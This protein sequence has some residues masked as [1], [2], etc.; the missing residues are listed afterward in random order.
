MSRPRIAVGGFMHETNTFAP[1][2]ADFAAFDGGG[3]RP[4][5]RGE[6]VI[7]L[8]RGTNNGIAG[9]VESPEAQAWEIVPTLW[10]HASP[11][12]HVTQDAFDRIA[13]E[14]VQAIKDAGPLD[15]I[16]LNLHGAMVAEHADDGEGELLRRVRAAMGDAIPIVVSL[17]LHANVTEEMVAYSDALIGYRTYPHVDMADTGARC[18]TYM[19]RIVGTPQRDAKAFRRI[20]FLIPIVWQ[21]TYIEPCKSLYA[22]HVTMEA[23]GLPTISFSTGFPA[24]DIPGCAPTVVAYAADAATAERAADE[25]ATMVND[26]ESA[27]AGQ[28]WT[29]DE[30]VMEAMRLAQTASKPVVIAD[31]QDNPGAGGDSDTTGM[32]RAL[33]A[34]DAQR[35]AIGNIVDPG[36]A[37]A[38]HQAGEGATVRL[39]LG[40]KSGV[41]GDMPLD[42]AFVVE[43]LTD[44]RFTA[45]G[46]FY[47]GAKLDLG[48]SACLRIG[49]VQIV[50]TSRKAQMADQ[51][52]YRQVGIEPCDQAI[53]V[54]KSS[55]HFRADFAPIAEAILVCASPGPMP[56][57]PAVLP[58]TKLLPGIRLSPS[59]APGQRV[60]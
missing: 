28:V 17:D 44:G 35:A 8:T 59:I 26:A 38:A 52:M 16:Y 18:A 4:I 31:T 12:A 2:R 22:H 45:T 30:G 50:V 51:Q 20:E 57:D 48:L 5:M 13:D 24:A 3:G 29:P 41:P 10:A 53:L 47:G 46:P 25:M 27:F 33:I 58:F 39:A 7:T 60:K 56:V 15:G 32:L 21:C 34:Q 49:G 23:A 40:G 1:T 37:A 42:E 36:A 6:D 43:K 14:L 19:A 11:S 9:F 55:V 54:N